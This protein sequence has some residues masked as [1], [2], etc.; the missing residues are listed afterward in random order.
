MQI[1]ML[2]YVKYTKC[3]CVKIETKKTLCLNL[4]HLIA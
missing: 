1:E 3:G 4:L 2:K